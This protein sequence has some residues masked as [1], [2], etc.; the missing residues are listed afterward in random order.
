MQIERESVST[1]CGALYSLT[2]LHLQK[3]VDRSR[4]ND[5]RGIIHCPNGIIQ[6]IFGII[7]CPYGIIP[8]CVRSQ[9]NNSTSARN[10]S[11]AVKNSFKKKDG[12]I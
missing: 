8:L 6:C 3:K 4:T 12:I 5:S 10:K 11:I 1:A 9:M 2:T 7:A